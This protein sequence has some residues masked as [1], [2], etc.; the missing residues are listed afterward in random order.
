M[1]DDLGLSHAKTLF[2]LSKWKS[3]NNSVM[4]GENSNKWKEEEARVMDVLGLQLAAD[5]ATDKAYFN[6]GGEEHLREMLE[7]EFLADE[8]VEEL[9]AEDLV[10]T[11]LPPSTSGDSDHCCHH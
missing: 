5:A 4:L 8:A 9:G 1:L 7:W 11:N 3:D 2:D 10:L 6:D